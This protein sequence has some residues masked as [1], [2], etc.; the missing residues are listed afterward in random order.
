MYWFGSN[1]GDRRVLG[2]YERHY[3]AYRY[4][5]GR[6]RNQ[7]VG[8]GEDMVLL[9]SNCDALF[10][11]RKFKSDAAEAGINCAVFRNEGPVLSS[12]LV[13]EACELAWLKWPGERLY[14]YVDPQA[15]RSRNP[16]CCF[17]KAHWRRLERRTQ[18]RRLVI[19]ER[20][21]EQVN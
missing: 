3:S 14:T 11:W 16:G 20:L 10:I 21:P 13:Q 5:D 6:K 2:I 4:R 12:L 7:C 1:R 17:L 19:L 9:T 15:I 18:K 8:P